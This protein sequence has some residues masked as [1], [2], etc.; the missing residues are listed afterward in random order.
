[1]V[2]KII[3]K[4]PNK[5]PQQELEDNEIQQDTQEEENNI[6][7]NKDKKPPMQIS[8]NIRKGLDGRLMI[9]DHD[10]IDVIFLPENKKLLAL[11]KDGYSDIIYQTQNR[12]FDFLIKKG[13]TSPES[14][15]GS[16]IY[17]A[18]EC[19]ILTPEK[20]IPAEQ[21]LVLTIQKWIELEKP[22]L[23]ADKEYEER[24]TDMLTDPESP[25]STELGEVPHEED[26]GSIPKYASRRYIGGW[27]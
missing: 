20:E 6:F 2:E 8:L 14:V 26:K 15:Q 5:E 27:W 3:L 10:H 23:E 16:N 9:F 7:N 17:G 24:F 18:M 13:L 4:N 22:S 12:L 1:M 19:V 21:L 25:D 11:S